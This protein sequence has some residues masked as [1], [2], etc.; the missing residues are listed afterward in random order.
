M[1]G[2]VGRGEA[3]GVP[4]VLLKRGP[5]ALEDWSVRYLSESRA[6]IPW[7]VRRLC[8]AGLYLRA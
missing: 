8:Q 1:S 5:E 2:G 3:Q 6:N 7:K 4:F